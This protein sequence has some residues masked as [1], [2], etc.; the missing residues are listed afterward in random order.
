[1]DKDYGP[2]VELLRRVLAAK[3]A[4][5]DLSASLPWPEKVAIAKRVHDACRKARACMDEYQAQLRHQRTR[6]GSVSP[7]KGVN[8]TMSD[9]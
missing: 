4:A 7:S 9:E 3:E 1:V 8:S 2:K 5:R 6:G